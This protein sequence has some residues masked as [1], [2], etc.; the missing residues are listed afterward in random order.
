MSNYFEDFTPGQTLSI[1]PAAPITDFDNTWFTLMTLNSNPLHFDAAFAAE[2]QHGKCLANGLLV[3]A[4]VTGMSVKDISENEIANFLSTNQSAYRA[5]L[6]RRHPVC[7]NHG[8]RR[9]TVEDQKRSWRS[10]CRDEGTQPKRRAGTPFA[11]AGADSA[12][13]RA[14]ASASLARP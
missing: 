4:L 5:D 2:S 3:I 14:A 1:C 8:D 7:G 11:A 12:A 9:D 6:Q 10:V 13:F